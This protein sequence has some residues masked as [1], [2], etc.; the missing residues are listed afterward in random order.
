MAIFSGPEIPNN[1]LV[2]HYDMSNSVKSWKGAPTTNLS[3]NSKDVSGSAY[4]SDDEWVFTE[5]TRFTK[6][7]NPSIG[8]PL[9]TG[10]TLLQESGINGYH[11]LS[12]WGGNEATGDHALSCY[13]YPIAANIDNF[14]IGLLGGGR[15]TYNLTN[16]TISYSDGSVVSGSGFIQDVPGYPGW[17]RIG[18]VIN[19]REGGWVGCIGLS[20]GTAY[21]GTSGSRS[22]YITGL[23]YERKTFSAAFI[24][25]QQT[26][27]NTQAILDLTNNNTITA[28][29]L[30]Y[31]G[32]GTFSFN[33]SSNRLNPPIN[34]SYLNS[35]ALEV[36]FR[37][38]SH[39]SGKKTVFGYRHNQGYSIPTI[40]SLYLDG[41]NLSASV[42]TAAQVYRVVTAAL[43]ISTNTFYHVVLNK[44]TIS[45]LLEIYVNGVLSGSQTFDAATYAQ[46]TT[47]G[48]FI[49]E[50]FLDIGKSNNMDAGQGWSTD[51]FSGT[52]PLAK[53]YNRVLSAAEVQ[54]NFEATRGRYGI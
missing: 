28:T 27:S 2:F 37:S 44:N 48:N 16:R 17:L 4:A 46:W 29:S 38:T 1:G 19:G 33:G 41:N 5:P 3:R 9:G 13:V 30:T 6:T 10:A 21:T 51:Y 52:I 42:I 15:L 12:R 24:E 26:R 7:Y 34:H 25:A 36:V 8:T 32:D 50:N 23:Q 14:S 54:Q 49:G 53:V 35:S 45:G 20:V 43:S 22:F 31:A 47:A 40:G 18:G 39:G 11:H